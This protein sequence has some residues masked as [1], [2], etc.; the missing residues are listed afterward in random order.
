M[1]VITYTLTTGITFGVVPSADFGEM[2]IAKIFA[3]VLVLQIL[4]VLRVSI[5]FGKPGQAEQ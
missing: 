3:A 4:I 5:W 1:D 2:T